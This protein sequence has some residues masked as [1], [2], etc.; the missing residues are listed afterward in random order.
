MRSIQR[1]H[2]IAQITGFCSDCKGFSTALKD[3]DRFR[4]EHLL[5]Q[6]VD[7]FYRNDGLLC[8]C[9]QLIVAIYEV[10]FPLRNVC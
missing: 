1:A 10:V 8:W 9:R 3:L 6:H 5:A 4:D 7:D 2:D